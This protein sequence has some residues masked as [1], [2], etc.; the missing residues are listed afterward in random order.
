MR[1]TQ[2]GGQTAAGP[3]DWFTGTVFIDAIRDPDEQSAR[4]AQATRSTSNRAKSTGTAPR[5]SDGSF[6][7]SV[8]STSEAIQELVSDSGWLVRG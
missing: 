4:S 8:V 7:V 5:L 2:S 1:F 6:A 3:K